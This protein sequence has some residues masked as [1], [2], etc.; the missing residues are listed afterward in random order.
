MPHLT[1][2]KV[3]HLQIEFVFADQETTFT[4]HKCQSIRRRTSVPFALWSSI[5]AILEWWSTMVYRYAA[6]VMMRDLSCQYNVC[7]FC[8]VVFPPNP[9]DEEDAYM[10]FR[11]STIS[12]SFRRDIEE[13]KFFHLFCSFSL[14]Y[15]Y[16]IYH[17]TVN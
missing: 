10:F 5:N 1:T 14:F 13:S 2:L 8:C 6:A 12:I 7:S 11:S 9:S 15:L 3:D 17:I 4:T 16:L